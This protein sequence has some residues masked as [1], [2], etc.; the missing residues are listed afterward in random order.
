MSLLT[1]DYH[2][3][4]K[5]ICDCWVVANSPVSKMCGWIFLGMGLYFPQVG[6]ISNVIEHGKFLQPIIS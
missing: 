4:E 5:C 6:L 2:H 1:R 3:Q